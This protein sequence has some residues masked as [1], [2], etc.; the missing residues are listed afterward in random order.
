MADY[1]K[2]VRD[3]AS[4]YVRVAFTVGDGTEISCW[5][6]WPAAKSRIAWN[7]RTARKKNTV[8]ACGSDTYCGVSALAGAAE[9]RDFVY[10]SWREF[11]LP[12]R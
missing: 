11:D 2:Y 9:N 4:G 8:C 10:F 7:I 5:T 12:S 3:L 1:L 6:A